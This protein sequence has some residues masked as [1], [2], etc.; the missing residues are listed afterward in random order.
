M[1]GR[2]G[3]WRLSEVPSIYAYIRG[4]FKAIIIWF[5]ETI[6]HCSITS[7]CAKGG[8]TTVKFIFFMTENI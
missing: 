2:F 3:S 6:V 1:L 7:K 8:A 4:T 5:A